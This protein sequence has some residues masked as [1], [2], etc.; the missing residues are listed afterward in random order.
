MHT[1]ANTKSILSKITSKTDED[2]AQK[3]PNPSEKNDNNNNTFQN[4]R[5]NMNPKDEKRHSSI[6]SQIENLRNARKNGPKINTDESEHS[7]DANASNENNR[8]LKEELLET[9]AKLRTITGKIG[10]LKKEK[11]NLNKENKTLQEEVMSLQ[12]SLR[13]MIPGFS[14]TGS[15]FPMFNELVSKV[16][17]FYKYDCEEIFFDLLCPELNMKGIIFFYFTSFSRM[18][19]LIQSYFAPAEMA[20]KKT[21]CMTNLDGPIMNV[22]RKSFQS[23]WKNISKQC[24]LH[25]KLMEVTNEI[26]DHLKLGET[27]EETNEKICEFLKKLGELVL[28]FYISDPPLVANFKAIGS[29]VIYNPTKHEPLDGFIKNKDEC[30]VVLPST[31]KN[32]IEGE[33]AS[34]ALVLQVDYEIPS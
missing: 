26:Q 17:E 4:D 20:L 19:E 27:S 14:N 8:G 23:T 3:P 21:A 5:L 9:K 18:C 6:L 30:I 34:K 7:H 29:K 13:Q 2:L 11:E 31:H 15:S 28:C 24:I 33:L 10:A 1:A 32:T 25:A 12:A 16:S 22:L